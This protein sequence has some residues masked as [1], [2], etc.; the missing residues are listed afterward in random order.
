MLQID[1]FR[2]YCYFYATHLFNK[3]S[4]EE[5]AAFKLKYKITGHEEHDVLS[6]AIIKFIF[7][8]KWV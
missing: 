2:E 5:L 6:D 3:I 1:G 4:D 8:K 7:K